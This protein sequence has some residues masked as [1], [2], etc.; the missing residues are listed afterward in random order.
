ML[1]SIANRL[2]AFPPALKGA[3]GCVSADDARWKPQ[4]PNYPKG[5][6]SVL[7]IVCHLADEEVLDFRAR[8]ESV[9]RDPGS[10]WAPIDPEGRAVEQRYNEQELGPALER[11]ERARAANVAWLRSQVAPDWS[12]VHRHPKFGPIAAGDLLVS[13]AA[14]DALHLRQIAKRLY[15]LAARDG[16]TFS[17]AYAG[18]WGA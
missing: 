10:A 12:A 17:T 15:Q 16:S 18:E 6:W 8:L 13:W 5:A 4:H 3:V 1:E 7:E 14:H 2:A 11:F 9:L